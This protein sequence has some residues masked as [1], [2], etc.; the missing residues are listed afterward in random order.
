MNSFRGPSFV[1]TDFTI[2]KD[3]AYKEKYKLKFGATAYN[4]LNHPN[5]AAPNNSVTTGSFGKITSTV[6]S[7]P[8]SLYGNGQGSAPSGRVLA[9]T[10]AFRF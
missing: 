9:L 3:I 4:V 2:T 7:S 10:G 8:S 1:D 5:F 6:V